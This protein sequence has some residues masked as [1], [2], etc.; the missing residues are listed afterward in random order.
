L[1]GAL[2]LGRTLISPD[3]AARIGATF[4]GIRVC[5][6]QSPYDVLAAALRAGDIDFI[7]GALRP[8]AET[9]GQVRV[10]LLREGTVVV[11]RHDHPLAASSRLSLDAFAD[12]RWILPR[13]H[14]PARGILDAR[15]HHA[16][17]PPPAAAVETADL[18]LIRGLLLH[19]D[20]LAA[21][22]A[23]QLHYEITSGELTILHIAMDGTKRIIG[24]LLREG[25][26]P[27][28][29]TLA[30]IEA[31][32]AVA[33]EMDSAMSGSPATERDPDQPA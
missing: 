20:M 19:T 18:A 23:H 7:L 13:S 30:M 25:S 33:A 24:L 3:A 5:T 12:A 14:A 21:V 29:T 28:P 17:L 15:F 9:A 4:P 26:Q 32:T 22:S 8:E 27:S 11:A 1:Q 10:P 16:G 6:D 2:P 31:V